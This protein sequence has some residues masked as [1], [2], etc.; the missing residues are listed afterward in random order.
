MNSHK[1]SKDQNRGAQQRPED[2][3]K[4]NAQQEREWREQQKGKFK[5]PPEQATDAKALEQFRDIEEKFKKETLE[6]E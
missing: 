5:H 1:N 6:E 3:Q 2:A 4:Q